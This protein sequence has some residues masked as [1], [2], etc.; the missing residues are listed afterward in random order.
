MGEGTDDSG[1]P[2]KMISLNC[3]V[4]INYNNPSQYFGAHID[5]VNVVMQ[6]SALDIAVG[7][8]LTYFQAKGTRKVISVGVQAAKVPLYGAVSGVSS[9]SKSKQGIPVSM[10]A[11][12][13]SKFYVVGK[14]IKSKFQN[15]VSCN[16]VVDSKT[17]ALLSPLGSS[18]TYSPPQ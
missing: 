8:I 12:L 4:Q 18:C 7:Q 2:T 16:L 14:M 15:E 13:H 11:T 6:Y 9:T 10:I 3:T 1:V 5:P 17:M